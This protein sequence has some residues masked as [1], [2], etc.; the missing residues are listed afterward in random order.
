MSNLL[1]VGL[2][3]G[4]TTVKI[5]V[6]D[7]NLNV[8]EQNSETIEEGYVIKTEPQQGVNRKKGTTIK[9]IISSGVSGVTIENYVGMNFYEVKGKLEAYGIKVV[10][11]LKDVEKDEKETVKENQIMEQRPIAGTKLVEGD[12]ITLI[13]P[14][15]VVNYPNF[16]EEKW[17][18][19]AI[20]KF[21][22]EYEVSV[23]FIEEETNAYEEG[24]VIKQDR[25]AGTRV[26][27]GYPLKITIAVSKDPIEE[28]LPKEEKSDGT[29]PETNEESIEKKEN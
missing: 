8:I 29:K 22:K 25:V 1:H 21:C 23:E 27:T 3:V 10:S 5:I 9:L 12:T 4:S 15:L 28:I 17:T 7:E 2:D 20:E 18:K 6:L 14:N 16:V 26:K 19:D 24:T 11:E 13:L